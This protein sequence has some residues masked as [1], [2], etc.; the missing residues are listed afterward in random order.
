VTG[1]VVAFVVVVSAI[2]L[3][4]QTA[5]PAVSAPAARDGR[6]QIVINP[7]VRA[8]TFLLDTQTGRMWRPAQYKELEG[9]PVVFVPF[10]KV[11]NA[12]E[13]S[14]WLARRKSK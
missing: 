13:L 5:R 2:A 6:F 9:E 11:D 1:I 8:D 14:A 10:D 4:A 12:A 3:L 7:E